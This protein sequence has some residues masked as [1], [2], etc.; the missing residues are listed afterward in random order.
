M[1]AKELIRVRKQEA[2]VATQKA[3]LSSVGMQINEAFSMRK[4]E[5]SLKSSTAI[6]HD[7]NMLVKLP[8]LSASM[9]ELSQELMKAG[10]IEEM[11]SDSMPETELEGEDEAAD[12]EVD[13][14]LGEVLKD[15]IQTPAVQVPDGQLG[16][17][18]VPAE[19]EQ[20]LDSEEILA[21]MRG[22]LEALKS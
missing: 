18:E 11:V 9:R 17:P 21:Q 7:V 5:T 4:I 20:D 6:M 19:A 15:R 14:V 13:K 1:F 16:E 12:A 10:I 2:R 8:A 22:R 3:T